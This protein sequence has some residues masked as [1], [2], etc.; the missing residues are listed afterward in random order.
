MVRKKR[1]PAK[2]HRCDSVVPDRQDKGYELPEYLRA[3]VPGAVRVTCGISGD[4]GNVWCEYV[5]TTALC[6]HTRHLE[7]ILGTRKTVCG[8]KAKKET[9]TF[10]IHSRDEVVHGYAEQ[11][12]VGCRL[13]LVAPSTLSGQRAGD[14]IARQAYRFDTE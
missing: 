11:R 7:G 2:L 13:Q 12:A 5:C 10:F 9:S 6:L 8:Y 3:K 4:V 14:D 1:K